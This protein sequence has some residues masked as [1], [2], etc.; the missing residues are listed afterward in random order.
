MSEAQHSNMSTS[1][2]AVT[3]YSNLRQEIVGGCFQLAEKNPF[4]SI[5]NNMCVPCYY[6][7][8]E[9][10]FETFEKLKQT[11]ELLALKSI[12]ENVVKMEY[13]VK[14]EMQ[15]SVHCRKM[16]WNE[17]NAFA[18]E[19]VSKKRCR[20][21]ALNERHFKELNLNQVFVRQ[22]PPEQSEQ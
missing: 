9:L 14:T 17:C 7:Q 18:V 19:A 21:L 8:Q 6:R 20:L 1:K 2:E 11:G 3:F 15:C 5:G 10:A 22:K 12:D 16:S 4:A 13:D